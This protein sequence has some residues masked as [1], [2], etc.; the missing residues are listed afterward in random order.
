[1]LPAA[2]IGLTLVVV[3]IC[4]T[5]SSMPTMQFAL[6]RA[7]GIAV[8]GDEHSEELVWDTGSEYSFLSS[9]AVRDGG[10]RTRPLAVP[11]CLR[12][13]SGSERMI[14]NEAIGVGLRAFEG[15]HHPDRLPVL[16]DPGEWFPF[17]G[18]IGRDTILAWDWIVDGP[19][20]LMV[21]VARGALREQLGL[22]GDLTSERV[23]MRF[24]KDGVFVHVRL[25]GRLDVE[26]RLD[27]GSWRTLLPAHIIEELDLPSGESAEFAQAER[28][29][30]LIA[31]KIRSAGI[32]VGE[33]TVA[34]SG[35]E[36]AGV[37]GARVALKSYVLGALEI[38]SV[39]EDGIVIC[40]AP[41][42]A[43]VI[44]AD[45]LRR[46]MWALDSESQAMWLLKD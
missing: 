43:V 2:V 25:S 23:P 12:D 32:V 31:E 42:G 41:S 18:I 21:R 7:F 11:I 39:R 36:A 6:S 10:L 24:D 46:W 22:H 29:A 40:E 35:A 38:G 17:S 16:A 3:A 37:H 1:V 14:V 45:V 27:T 9:V 13:S 4:C 20:G 26:A 28:D 44:G 15:R 33:P 19:R 34:P 30:K 5:H 8:A